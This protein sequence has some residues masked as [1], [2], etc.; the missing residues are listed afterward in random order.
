MKFISFS[1]LDHPATLGDS[2]STAFPSYS[3]CVKAILENRG[4]TAAV[5]P[6]TKRHGLEIRESIF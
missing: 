1:A 4:K 2:F 5:T 3:V 6:S